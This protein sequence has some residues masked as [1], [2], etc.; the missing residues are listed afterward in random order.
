MNFAHL[1]KTEARL[2][3][4]TTW[5]Y[6]FETVTTMIMVSLVFLALF[7][8]IQSFYDKPGE[9]PSLDGLLFGYI[10]WFFSIAAFTSSSQSMILANQ[11]GVI[12]QLFL[13]P[14][15]LV[16]LILA[17]VVVI[18][19]WNLLLVTAL[20]YIAMALTGKWLNINFAVFYLILLAAAPSLIGIGLMVTGLALVFKR[21][22]TVSGVVLMSCM[23]LVA[24]DGYPINGF[25]LLPFTLG[26]SIARDNVIGGVPLDFGALALVFLNS[27]VYLALGIVVYKA[28]EK[29][30]KRLN[31][32]GHY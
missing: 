30:A 22:Q 17:R 32:I 18:V 16:Q 7:Y 31:L 19:L 25:S 28:F 24:V 15:G 3:L 14:L 12:S 8:G 23:A 26:A 27:F 9:V 1:L 20:A 13:C 29:R 5:A 10:I 4:I 11:T 6:W 2:H 21:V